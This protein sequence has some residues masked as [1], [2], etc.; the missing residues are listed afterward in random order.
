MLA[1]LPYFQE[2]GDQTL[3]LSHVT[4]S[5]QLFPAQR[6]LWSLKHRSKCLAFVVFLWDQGKRK[7]RAEKWDLHLPVLVPH[8]FPVFLSF[9]DHGAALPHPLWPRNVCQ[10]DAWVLEGMLPSPCVHSNGKEPLGWGTE[11]VSFTGSFLEHTFAETSLFD[12]LQ[13]TDVRHNSAHTVSGNRLCDETSPI[14]KVLAE[15]WGQTASKQCT[16]KHVAFLA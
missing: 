5:S 6:H 3:P 11:P 8:I 16:R 13:W 15:I 12:S 10:M 14:L 2:G 4:S 9:G 7:L 1:V